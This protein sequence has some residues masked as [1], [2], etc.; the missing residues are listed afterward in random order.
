MDDLTSNCDL[1]AEKDFPDQQ[2]DREVKQHHQHQQLQQE[3]QKQQ[4][5]QDHQQHQQQLQEQQQ[6][7]LQQYQQ[8]QLKRQPQQ[9]QSPDNPDNMAVAILENNT[10]PP[11]LR[12]FAEAVETE[13]RVAERLLSNSTFD[14]A[15]ARSMVLMLRRLVLQHRATGCDDLQMEALVLRRARRI[16]ESLVAGVNQVG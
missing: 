4:E 2:Q 10:L 3:Q 1:D 14:L 13:F 9:E 11:A 7:A 5:V 15:A 8:D 16:L 12:D 6:E